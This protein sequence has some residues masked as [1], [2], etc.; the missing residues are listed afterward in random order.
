[1]NRSMDDKTKRLLDPLMSV[2]RRLRW[3]AIA[4]GIGWCLAIFVG[5]AALQLMLDRLLVLGVGPR[6]VLLVALAA[7][8]V[9]EIWRRIGRPLGL[10]VDAVGVAQLIERKRHDSGDGLLSAVAFVSGDAVNPLRNSPAMVQAVIDRAVEKAYSATSDGL[11]RRDR[12]HAFLGVSGAALAVCAVVTA[13]APDTVGA[14]V[15]RNWLL[16]EAAWPSSSTIVPEGFENGRLRWPMG[17]EFTLV[18][19]AVDRVPR[20]LHAEMEYET[21]DALTRSMDR[22]GRDQFVLDVGPL[23]GSLRVRF[24][25]GKFGVD[26]HTQWYDIEAVPRPFVKKA[27][28]EVHPPEYSREAAYVLPQGQVSADLISGSRVRI[29]ATFSHPVVEAALKHRA[30]ESEAAAAAIDNGVHVVA[31]FEPTRRGTYYFDARDADGLED[32]RPVTYSLNLLKDPPPKARLTIPDSGELIVPNASL[33]LAVHCEDNL[34]LRD[35]VL[36]YRVEQSDDGVDDSMQSESL[37]NLTSGQLRYDVET[38]WPL[39]PLT[40]KP[41]DRLKVQ[42]QATDFQPEQ[43]AQPAPESATATAPDVASPAANLGESIAYTLR[44]VTPE[45]LLAELGRRENEWRREFEQIIKSQ[46]QMN[47]RVLDLVDASPQAAE[48]ATWEARIAQEARTQRQIAGRVRTVLRQFEM[49]FG[50]IKTNE[51]ATPTVRKRLGQGVI[52]PM[53]LLL[54]EDIPQAAETLE[55]LRESSDSGLSEDIETRQRQ[56]VRRMYAIL[57]EMIKWEGYNEAVALLRDV[58]RLQKDVSE[59]T[60][61]ELEQEIERMFDSNSDSPGGRDSEKTP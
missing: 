24:R 40:L 54:A 36:V 7:L 55:G 49:I 4:E 61:R 28:I 18:A 26:E 50:E 9:R 45:E 37:P 57:A 59:D 3:Y 46:E 41:G 47:V 48:R 20:T 1:M 27:T 51:L 5:A 15:Q 21:G 60:R 34:G 58:L 52:G 30:E 32:T 19:K 44:V 16:G 13:L 6:L 14:Y 43:A 29:E 33:N 56:I 31:D 23:P 39:L 10:R 38:I 8:L 53:R 22:R 25:I 11:L 12:Y 17:D 42:V 35:V 2:G